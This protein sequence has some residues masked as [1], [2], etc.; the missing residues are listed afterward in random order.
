VGGGESERAR[1]KRVCVCVR[2]SCC[3]L[4]TLTTS[5]CRL[6]TSPTFSNQA[7]F[8]T[9]GPS[10]SL[11]CKAGSS[12]L[13]EVEAL[14]NEGVRAATRPGGV[15]RR[16]SQRLRSGCNPAQPSSPAACCY[17]RLLPTTDTRGVPLPPSLPALRTPGA[18][19]GAAQLAV[20][21]QRGKSA[22]GVEARCAL[23]ALLLAD[24]YLG[25]RGVAGLASS[26]TPVRALTF[27]P[28]SSV[29]RL[30]ACWVGRRRCR[31]GC[32]WHATA[33]WWRARMCGWGSEHAC[34]LL[35]VVGRRLALHRLVQGSPTY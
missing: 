12:V 31:D 14:V 34:A 20:G 19:R 29:R 2:E 17:I 27:A 35:A 8:W 10:E 18:A 30:D 21:L 32:E 11:G 4:F 26:I 33:L 7:S 1:D 25:A 13:G 9:E 3:H 24:N 5:L 23:K 16:S 15:Q 28:C 22:L 6:S